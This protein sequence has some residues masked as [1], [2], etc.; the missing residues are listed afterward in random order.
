MSNEQKI[1]EKLK[2]SLIRLS[3]EFKI[4]K[5]DIRLKLVKT[6]GKLKLFLMNRDTVVNEQGIKS[7]FNL[8]LLETPVVLAYLFKM[9]NRFISENRT[10]QVAFVVSAKNNECEPRLDLFVSGIH[11]KE[12]DKSEILN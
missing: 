1:I 5:Q 6:G 11:K 8:S 7:A 12:L 9:M 10:D 4:S 3:A 2:F